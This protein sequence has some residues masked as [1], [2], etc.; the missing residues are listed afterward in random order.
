MGP[1]VDAI[2]GA[3][4]CDVGA[5]VDEEVG[6]G[7]RA[8][9]AMHVGAK[10]ANRMVRQ[11]FQIAGQQVLLTKLNVVDAGVCRFGDLLEQ[12]LALG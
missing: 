9:L 3:G 4:Q 7:A 5:G 12:A 6:A 8:R 11:G 2:G 1:Q 10:D